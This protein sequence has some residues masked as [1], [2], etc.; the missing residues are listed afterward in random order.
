MV[1]FVEDAEDYR[2]TRERVLFTPHQALETFFKYLELD[3]EASVNCH[4]NAS[5][6]N[7]NGVG[8]AETTCARYSKKLGMRQEAV[9]DT[10]L[11]GRSAEDVREYEAAVARRAAEL[12][13]ARGELKVKMKRNSNRTLE[14]LEAELP[15][16]FA[17]YTL[18]DEP[19]LIGRIGFHHLMRDSRLNTN[20]LSCAEADN[21][22]VKEEQ[23]EYEDLEQCV[24]GDLKMNYKEFV[25]IIK[26]LA[27]RKYPYAD[28][29]QDGYKRVLS[30][31]LVPFA[32]VK[33]SKERFHV[34]EKC[35]PHPDPLQVNTQF[36]AEGV[37][38]MHKYDQVLKKIYAHYATLDQPLA[39]HCTWKAVRRRG[40]TLCRD[41]MMLFMIN[42]G[43]LPNLITRQKLM[44]VF[45]AVEAENDADEEVDEVVFPAFVELLSRMAG[46][47]A[48]NVHQ[49]LLDSSTTV[50]QLNDAKKFLYCAPVEVQD[51]FEMLVKQ[52]GHG[53]KGR[54]NFQVE[55]I[56]FHER[57]QENFRKAEE[58]VLLEEQRK[59]QV[60]KALK[61]S[62]VSSE[63]QLKERN[64]ARRIVGKPRVLP[65]MDAAA[66]GSA[67]KSLPAPQ[68]PP[69]FPNGMS[70]ELVMH[71]AEGLPLFGALAG[72]VKRKKLSTVHTKY[73]LGKGVPLRGLGE[74]PERFEVADELEAFEERLPLLQVP[75]GK[76][77][78]SFGDQ[79]NRCTRALKSMSDFTPLEQWA[80]KPTL[81]PKEDGQHIN[82][83]KSF[84]R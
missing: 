57:M 45:R 52:R 81:P 25:K 20:A 68:A 41:E 66:A 23:R 10:T 61:D 58:S 73:T 65:K 54:L 5:G 49:Y 31:Y 11:Y 79:N 3:N 53:L 50:T 4:I 24:V 29:P 59:S 84:I 36:T 37:E 26:S 9:D 76:V 8:A 63:Q 6:K 38:N 14:D 28:D 43:I 56:D 64:R 48:C 7:V 77:V 30:Q 2:A 17:A 1:K 18:E 60:R 46:I 32:K 12:A 39:Q 55:K 72:E 80:M 70:F 15:G 83:Y 71:S 42:F 13:S 51:G 67:L 19:H 75:P 78:E 69:L 16:I 47:V 40:N 82:V 22:F 21:L 44:E 34:P 35:V 27:A 74:S 33:A 62:I